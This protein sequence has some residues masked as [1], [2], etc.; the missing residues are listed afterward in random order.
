VLTLGHADAGIYVN[1][2]S[3]WT[4]SWADANGSHTDFSPAGEPIEDAGGHLQHAMS[5]AAPEVGMSS[6][7]CIAWAPA[8]SAVSTAG[9]GGSSLGAQIVNRYQDGALT[10][11]PL[12][13]PC[14]GAFPCGAVVAGINDGPIACSNLHSRLRIDDRSACPLP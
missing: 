13:D 3:D 10:D 14:T 1:G 7:Q 2:V 11:E 4:V 12:W 8:G 6:G 9:A 5:V